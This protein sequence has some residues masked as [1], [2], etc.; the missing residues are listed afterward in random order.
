MRSR[1][2]LDL[3]LLVACAGALAPA[4][5]EE[6]Q[7]GCEVPAYLLATDSQLPKVAEAVKSGHPLDILVVGSRSSTINGSETNAYPARLQASLKEKL[8]QASVNL[9]VEV[10]SKKTAEDMGG[11]FAK[12]MEE[13]KPTLVVW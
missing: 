5:A 12:L 7:Q 9:S 6:A 1:V 4:H 8:P 3:L 2:I 10:Q 11:G 13:K